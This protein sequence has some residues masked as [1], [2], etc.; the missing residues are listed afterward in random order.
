[1]SSS[2]G[3]VIGNLCPERI[4][5]EFDKIWLHS[6]KLVFKSTY[7]LG[8]GEITQREG[9]GDAS[10]AEAEEDGEGEERNQ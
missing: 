5:P 4:R 8:E 1:M 7:N 2:Q 6:S 3:L 10:D 9:E